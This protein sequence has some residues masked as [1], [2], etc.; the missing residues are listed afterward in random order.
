M[1]IKTVALGNNEESYIEKRIS[2]GVNIILSDDNN[3][4]KTILI[5]SMFY[6][7]GNN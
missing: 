3:K 7:I 2:D 6:A 5:Q 1:I 4:G